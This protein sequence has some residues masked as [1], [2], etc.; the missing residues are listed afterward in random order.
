MAERTQ[1]EQPSTEGV[2]QEEAAAGGTRQGQPSIESVQQEETAFEEAQQEQPSVEGVQQEEAAVEEAQG[3][4][5]AAEQPYEKQV[6]LETGRGEIVLELYPQA[7]PRHVEAFVKRVE[8]GF[9]DG[10]A[11]H[12]AIPYGIVQ[13]GDPLSRDP[14]NRE[15]YGTGGLNE[16]AR[17]DSPVSHTRGTLSAVLIPGRPDS[18]GSQFFICVTDQT[19]LDGQ[20]TAFG[21]VVEGIE[22]TEEI[23][24]IPTDDSQLLTE[25][26]EIERAYLRDP[27][28]P[29]VIPFVDTPVEQLKG[30][31]AV[32]HTSY[33]D[34]EIELFPEDAP[35]HVRQFL[36]FAQLGLYDQTLFHRVV[37]GF[38]V[39]GGS[40][41]NRQPPVADKYR[42]LL[43]S[44]PLELN[45]HQHFK[46]TVS[47][48]RSE[49]PD[50]AVD[51]FFISLGRH[52]YLDDTYTVFGQVTSGIEV[53]DEIASVR[54]DGEAPVTPIPITIEVLLPPDR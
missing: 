29:E 10:T 34:I 49:E 24:Q 12:R 19:Q 8:G 5:P 26:V 25:R 15:Q 36:R 33:G 4:E 1:H 42:P 13:G 38:V 37:P 27:P 50:S 32:I 7:A 16:L 39:Q 3:E 31:G 46:G 53:V 48:A 20:F 14:A 22:V 43:Q 52:E 28:P 17:E 2:Q 51:S 54:L 11:I 21:R 35:R 6:V 40:I 9:Y 30:Y 44:L 47:M 18:A 41:E 23:S 45:D